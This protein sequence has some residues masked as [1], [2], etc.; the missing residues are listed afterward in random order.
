MEDLTTHKTWARALTSAAALC[1]SLLALSSAALAGDKDL[2]LRRLAEAA[3]SDT[4]PGKFNAVP[5][6]TAFR[7]LSKDLGLVFAPKFLAPAETLGEA[8]FDVGME[9]SLSTVDANAAHWR[10]L[11]GGSPDNF[12]TGQLH[13]RKGLPFSLELG[14]SLTHLFES[15]MYALGTEARLALNEGFFYLPDLAVRGTFNTVLGS[16]DLN[17]ATLGFDVSI[18][19]SFGVFGVLNITPYAGYNYLTI[20]ASSRLLDVT[21]EDPTPPTLDETTGELQFQPEFVFSTQTQSINR[22]FGGVRFLIGVLNLTFEGAFA[23]SVQSYSGRIGFD[24]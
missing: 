16:S 21:P 12:L 6:L 20:I 10:A 9:L 22:F 18:S 23:D 13:V 4:V 3:P 7:G 8:G 14:G 11:D 5:D 2:T 17:L 15:E 24:F 19:K 1:V